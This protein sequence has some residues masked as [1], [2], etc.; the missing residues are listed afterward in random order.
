VKG[1]QKD[2]RNKKSAP[3]GRLEPNVDVESERNPVR[4]ARTPAFG[5]LESIAITLTS[6]YTGT[7]DV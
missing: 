7:F 6:Q 4:A 3:N 1:Q 2:D 5:I